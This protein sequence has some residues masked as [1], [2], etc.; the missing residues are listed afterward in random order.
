M[1]AAA[2]GWLLLAPA[3]ALAA[4]TTTPTG[5]DTPLNLPAETPSKALEVGGG[6][7]GSLVRLVF[8]L[9]L[10]VGAIYL[11]AW[12]LRKVK[13]A[14]QTSATGFGL[15]SEATIP[16]G[17]GRSVHLIRAGREL[18]LVGS[19]EHGVVPLRTYS[20]EEARDLGLIADQ[21][22][23]QPPARPRGGSPAGG[24][25]TSVVEALRRRTAR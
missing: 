13:G 5:E 25:T 20:E 23:A 10:V 19:A 8:G 4:T 24:L 2:C 17:P 9:A 12:V 15:S 6:G 1:L 21:D 7:G 18:V 22:D 11:V 16:L 3:H 14:Q